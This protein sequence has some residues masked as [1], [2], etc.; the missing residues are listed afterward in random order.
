MALATSAL[1][2]TRSLA[3]S[4][5]EISQ[6]AQAALHGLYST[7]AVARAVGLEAKAILVF[8]RIMKGGFVVGGTR[9]RAGTGALIIKGK[10]VR[11]Y[12]AVAS[13]QAFQTRLQRFSAA[14]FF[15]NNSNLG[16]LNQPKRWE[17]ASTPGLVVVDPG[18]EKSLV[19]TAPRKEVYVFLFDENGSLE[20]I[21]LKGTRISPYTPSG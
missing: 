7:D 10:A 5:A 8:P 1:Q 15:M 21:G 13:A 19:D 17:V 3:D 18:L 16:Y 12:N 9:A 2:P 14:I 11:Y 6:H 20:G 4:A